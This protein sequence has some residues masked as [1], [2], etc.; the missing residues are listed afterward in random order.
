MKPNYRCCVSCRKVDHKSTFWR[1][2]RI[3]P[4][5]QVQLDRGMGRSAYLCPDERCLQ[6]AQKKGRLGRV[7]KATVPETIFRSLQQRLVAQPPSKGLESS[8]DQIKTER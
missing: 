1:I 4:S 5:H 3:Y 8:V 6:F 7:L 2:V